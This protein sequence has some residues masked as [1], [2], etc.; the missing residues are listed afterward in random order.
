MNAKFGQIFLTH[1][2]SHLHNKRIKDSSAGFTL[3]ELLVVIIIIGI[4]AAIALPSF[5]NQTAKARQAEAKS[6]IGALN[7]GQHAYYSEK[8]IFSDDIRRLGVGLTSSTQNYQYTAEGVPALLTDRITNKATAINAAIRSYAG[9]VVMVNGTNEALI[10]YKICV[11]NS[12]GSAAI[13]NGTILLNEPECPTP[14]FSAD[15]N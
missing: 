12:A 14:G 15:T 9:V 6:Y 10:K 11:A 4:L 2:L 8:L 13:P 7:K 5:L 3:I 1:I